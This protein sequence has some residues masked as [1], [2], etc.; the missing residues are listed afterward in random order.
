SIGVPAT[1]KTD[2]ADRF[3]C[4]TRLSIVL[5]SDSRRIPRL[6]PGSH[7][8][9]VPASALPT[10][11]LCAADPRRIRHGGAAGGGAILG[12][13]RGLPGAQSGRQHSGAGGGRTAGRA[14]LKHHRRIYRGD[15]AAL[16]GGRPSDAA[17]RRAAR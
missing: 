8:H 10:V 7:V 11:A 12:T 2:T 17:D 1:K 5:A 13:A 14:R 9:V 4:T 6:A 15:A 3:A 16:A